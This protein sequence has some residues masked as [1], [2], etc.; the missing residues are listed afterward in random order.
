MSEERTA[1]LLGASGLVG[2][3]CL[4]LLLA[5]PGYRS[6]TA[7]LRR[8]LSFNHEK[9]TER[10][11]NF[12]LLGEDRDLF[13]VDDIYCCLGTTIRK[14]GSREAFRKV[15][16]EY[17][18]AAARLGAA[19]GAKRLMLVSSLGA[20]P[21]ATS[22]YVQVKGETEEGVRSANLPFTAI[23]RPS[24]LLGERKEFRIFEVLAAPVARAVSVA[25]IGKWRKYRSIQAEVVARAMIRSAWSA[26]AGVEIFESD[27]IQELG[28]EKPAG[29]VSQHNP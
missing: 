28:A 24:L 14:A 3:Q 4:H 22:F 21:A 2:G 20:N 26:G 18:V 29:E 1:L 9:L 23:F 12:D 8:P 6:V 19:V 15:D 5:E 7:V 27:R 25:M 13:A 17:P 11:L 16:Y 10:L